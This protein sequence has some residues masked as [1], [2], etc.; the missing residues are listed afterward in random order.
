[1]EKESGLRVPESRKASSGSM[2]RTVCKTGLKSKNVYKVYNAADAGISV[3]ASGSGD[4]ERRLF[5]C[6][7]LL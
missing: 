2:P 4:R 7:F 3:C 6:H 1:L 5:F